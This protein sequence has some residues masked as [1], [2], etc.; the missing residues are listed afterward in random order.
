MGELERWRVGRKVG[1]TI[2]RQ[3]GEHPSDADLLIGVMDTPELAGEVVAAR[4]R[5][6]APK[7]SFHANHLGDEPYMLID[8]QRVG[9]RDWI[10]SVEARLGP[11]CGDDL[12]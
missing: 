8:G 10:K 9:M 11:A 2:Y 1:R 7:V 3:V 12:A 4:G 6:I 5:V